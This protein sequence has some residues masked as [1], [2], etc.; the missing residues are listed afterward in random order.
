MYCMVH[1]TYSSNRFM[2]LSEEAEEEDDD[3]DEFEEEQQPRRRRGK[4]KYLHP[5]YLFGMRKPYI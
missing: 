1:T 4:G 5:E 2:F 3:D